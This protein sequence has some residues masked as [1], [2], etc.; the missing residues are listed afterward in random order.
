MD[1]I[2]TTQAIAS[3]NNIASIGSTLIGN[4]NPQQAGASSAMRVNRTGIGRANTNQP[5]TGITGSMINAARVAAGNTTRRNTGSFLGNPSSMVNSIMRGRNTTNQNQL[6]PT[7]INPRAFNTRTVGQVF[8]PITNSPLAQE[9]SSPLKQDMNNSVDPMTGQYI[10]PTMSQGL[11][12]G[13]V[14]PMLGQEDTSLT[15]Y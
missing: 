12:P 6:T 13:T 11:D 2:L 14:D 10:D 9:K 4:Q 7:A 3:A 5:Q 15:Q 8:N 1:S